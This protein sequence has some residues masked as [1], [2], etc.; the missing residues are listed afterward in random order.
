MSSLK[1]MYRTVLKDTFPDTMT[2]TLGDAV[3]TYKKRTWHIDGE[4]KGLR[5]GENPDQPAALYE[6]ES[7]KLA[8]DGVEW[9]GPQGIMSA[10]TEAQMLQ[11][12]KHPGK[13]NLTDVDNG[14]N[15]LQYLA[16]RPAA[17]ILKHNNPCGAA[18][19][20]ES[21]GDALAKAFWCD[22][23]AAFGGA[24]VVNRPL[25][26]QAADL[27][28]A[29]YFEVVAAPDFEEGV[30]EKLAARK[31]LRIFKLPALARLGELA[32]VPFLDVKSMADGG[33]ILQ[34]S[35]VNRI[36]SAADFI[37]A[38][39]TTKDGLTV[40]ARKP[41]PQEADDLVFAW[42]VEA[43]VTSNSVIF[44]HNGATVAIGTGEQDRVGCVE[45]AIFKAYT[46]YADTLAFT[47]HGMTLYEL[48]LKASPRRSRR[49]ARR[50]RSGHPEGQ[51][52]PRRYGARL[53][54]LLPLPRRRGRVHR[55]GRDR[56]RAA[57]RLPPR[58]R[59]HRGRQRSLPAGGDGLHRPAFVQ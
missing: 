30:L 27:I 28:A 2:I 48:K 55:A 53:R 35:F 18:W 36:R 19:S 58:L 17:V 56:H 14:C 44:A 5:Y 54:R 50:H 15:I 6:M 41:T 12:G 49:T 42:A 45:L 26:M 46:K 3:L 38:V 11:A 8:I 43:G 21:V 16:E 40:S 25:D 33:I 22:R 7:G 4:T 23:I 34:Q 13:T 20:K 59:S 51:G 29:N 57:R 37:P 31:N 47:R 32:G 39:A 52:R 24:V 10:L 9:R 1:D